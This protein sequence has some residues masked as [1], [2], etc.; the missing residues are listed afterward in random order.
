MLKKIYRQYYLNNTIMLL[1]SLSGALFC[2][3]VF[4][5][6]ELFPDAVGG[7]KIITVAIL[8]IFLLLMITSIK[9]LFKSPE[10][11]IEKYVQ[12]NPDVTI[13]LLEEDFKNAF[14][15]NHYLWI[16]FRYIFCLDTNFH[17]YVLPINRITGFRAKLFEGLGKTPSK[18][19]ILLV[20]V[21]GNEYHIYTTSNKRTQKALELIKQNKN[22]L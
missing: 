2:I 16:G 14:A 12:E 3:F 8:V 10:R 20:D 9:Q 22:N 17:I 5:Y 11:E 6:P 4:L 19:G 15:I 1:I 13:D 18:S 7:I 21:E